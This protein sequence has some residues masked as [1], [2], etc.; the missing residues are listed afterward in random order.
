MLIKIFLFFSI[1]FSSFTVGESLYEFDSIEDEK[2]F[3]TLIKEIRCPKC[4]SGSL[5]SSNAP[6]SE[7]IKSKIIQLI[8]EG[9]S[10]Q[11]IK[12]FLSD[13]FGNQVLYNPGL[14]KDTYFLVVCTWFVFNT[15]SSFFLFQKKNIMIIVYLLAFIS[16]FPVYAYLLAPK[17]KNKGYIFG[18]SFLILIFCLFSFVGKYSFLGSIKEQEI[19]N[20]IFLIIE[21]DN[22][23]PV[24]LFNSFD[25]IIDEESKL[26]WAQS[27]IQKAM[28]E[29]KLQAAESLISFS[30]KYFMTSD[31]KFIFYTLYTQLRDLK[32]PIFANSKFILNLSPP[33]DCENYKGN[34][35]LF[36]MNGPNIPIASQNFQ[37]SFEVS[38]GN[39]N[40][41]IPGFDLASAYLNQEALELKASLFCV[42]KNLDYFSENA[43]LFDQ[44]NHINTYNIRPNE[45]LKREQ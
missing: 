33:A 24:N 12:E 34:I 4:T 3:Y 22:E 13:R 42:E 41:S 45:W 1:I 16:L 23:I 37:N 2:R 9:K 44:N 36:I 15:N 5:A 32:F 38:L 40:S 43:L 14:S 29:Q 21:Q 30:E 31:E 7:D 20:K 26:Y 25:A 6:V 19:N 17:T 35:S 27:Y 39:N 11:E 10:D 8:K 18:I 28:S